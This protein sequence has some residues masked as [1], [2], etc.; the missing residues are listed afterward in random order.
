V[1]SHY[2]APKLL[3]LPLYL[4]SSNS[5]NEPT[6]SGQLANSSSPPLEPSSSPWL[7]NEPHRPDR[8][9]TAFRSNTSGL[10]RHGRYQRQGGRH[11]LSWTAHDRSGPAEHH[12]HGGPQTSHF[13]RRFPTPS[14]KRRQRPIFRESRACS[15][16]IVNVHHQLARCPHDLGLEEQP[17]LSQRSNGQVPQRQRV[18]ICARRIPDRDTD[19]MHHPARQTRKQEAKRSTCRNRSTVPRRVHLNPA[20]RTVVSPIPS[21]VEAVPKNHHKNVYLRSGQ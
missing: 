15:S 9:R 2:T 7:C 17:N 1:G 3:Q 6:T 10:G 4:T 14:Q 19:R 16:W 5:E 11:R 12:P 13:G 18:A 21:P 8:C 20:T